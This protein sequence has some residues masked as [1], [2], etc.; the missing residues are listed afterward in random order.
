MAAA[1][2][3]VHLLFN[4]KIYNYLQ[5]WRELEMRGHR[6]RTSHSDTEVILN[7]YL[8]WNTGVFARLDGMV[9]I[10]IWFRTEPPTS[11]RT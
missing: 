9:A 8:E 5:L 11:P 1:D 3:R 4:G 6:F 10:A 2:A 7:G